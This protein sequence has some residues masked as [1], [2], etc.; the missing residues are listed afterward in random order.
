MKI[1]Y[2]PN[3]IALNARPVLDAFLQGCQQLG[4][5]TVENTSDAD[6]AVIWSVLW[7]G[8]MKENQQ[9]YQYF[10]SQGKPVYVL[11]VGML[12][13]GQTWKLGVNGT[14]VDCYNFTP[15]EDRIQKLGLQLK[16]WQKSGVN[17][18]VAV[19]RSDSEQWNGLPPTT[20]WLNDTIKALRQ[21]TDRPII[22]R[23]HPRQRIQSIPGTVIE[24][25]V[26]IPGSYDSFDFNR[27]LNSAWAVINWNSGAGPQ[28]I[29]NGVP[30]FVGASSLASSIANFD[31]SQIENPLRL[32]RDK[33]LNQIAH[34]EWYI[35]ELSTGLPLQRLL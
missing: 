5:N 26:A 7:H 1:A 30:A 25:P 2:F 6:A 15:T 13:R 18:V 10:R 34:S 17:I 20:V 31:L 32:E 23:P 27:C 3:Q 22:I 21:H 12:K 11:E 33:W 14:G 9:I 19:Q 28:A 4:I 16:D 35:H 8:R 24:S 29:I